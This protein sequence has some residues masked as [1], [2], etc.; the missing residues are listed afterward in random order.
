MH[1]GNPP[2]SALFLTQRSRVLNVKSTI[3]GAV[4]LL[5]TALF[6]ATAPSLSLA[7]ETEFRSLITEGDQVPA[8]V[9]NDLRGAEFDIRKLRGKVV[10]IN[11]WATWCTPCLVEMPY[12]EEEVWQRY[13]SDD[14]DMI[15]I[16]RGETAE[17]IQS[18]LS[19]H[20]Y[21]FRTAADPGREVYGL[22][23]E[24]GLPRS[25]LI[26]ANGQ[27][28]F[29]SVGIDEADFD[30]LQRAITRELA[31]LREPGKVHE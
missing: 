12:L 1:Q 7:G 16:A 23:S 24:E 22:F 4:V 11:F 19:R 3:R 9:I 10:L 13:R 8:F 27:V 18:F 15:A 6:T 26:G 28:V 31:I 29:Q 14:F 17:E 20:P 25:Y 2:K 30:R 5:C 21:S